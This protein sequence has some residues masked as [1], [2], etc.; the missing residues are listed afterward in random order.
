MILSVGLTEEVVRLTLVGVY[1]PVEGE[2]V[3]TAVS[4]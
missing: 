2:V 4:M 3:V 1:D